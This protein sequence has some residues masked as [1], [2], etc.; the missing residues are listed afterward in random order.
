MGPAFVENMPVRKFHGVGPSTSAKMERLGIHTGMDLRARSLA[1]LIEHFGKTGRHF[2]WISRAVDERAV[3]PDRVRKS[4]GAEKTFLQDLAE[5][6]G[7]REALSPIAEKVWRHAEAARAKGRTV[8]LKVKFA[9]FELITRSRSLAQPVETKDELRHIGENLLA[10]LF[11]MRKAVRLLGL[12]LSSFETE[13]AASDRQLT[14][15]L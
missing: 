12:S 2:Y 8:T 13:E 1:F 5:F 10:A 11:P 7:M 14:L 9:D 4:I 3:R 6:E 15:A